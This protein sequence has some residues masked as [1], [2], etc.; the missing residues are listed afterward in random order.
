MTTL[1]ERLR[2]SA[3]HQ[4][5]VQM[6]QYEVLDLADAL[7]AAEKALAFYARGCDTA[8]SIEAAE[9]GDVDLARGTE[10][11]CEDF[12]DVARAALS[13]LRGTK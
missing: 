10:A 5:T 2:D 1:A 9:R 8:T 4:L 12:G 7:D 3:K 6:S 13:N 11:F